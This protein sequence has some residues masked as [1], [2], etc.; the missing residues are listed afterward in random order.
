MVTG[1]VHGQAEDV[2]ALTGSLE[3]AVSTLR[4]LLGRGA[5][6]VRPPAIIT[7]HLKK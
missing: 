2:T 5:E 3:G 7:H 4:K 6:N 1:T